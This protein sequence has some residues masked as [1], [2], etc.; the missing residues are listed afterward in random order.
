M[1]SFKPAFSCSSFTFI[2]RLFS[3]SLSAIRMH[4]KKHRYHFAH[5][6][7]YSSNCGLFSG[8]IW[9]KS[10]AIKK[11]ECQK[12]D[13]FK[14]WCWIGLCKEIKPVNPKSNQSWIF[15]GRTDA[16][17]EAPK[18]WPPNGKKW[19][20][21][22]DP[23]AGKDWKQKKWAP[24]DEIVKFHHWLNEHEFEQISGDSEVQG[25]LAYCSPWGY[26][27]QIHLATKQ[28]PP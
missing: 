15:I 18:L 28:H 14:L 8:H 17:V 5:K 20:I 26:K 9:I 7:A 21:G 3:S 1:L 13:A 16:E 24:E 4:I 2:K 12:I 25:S 23:D 11:P 22:K 27:L 6:S 19:L 10:G